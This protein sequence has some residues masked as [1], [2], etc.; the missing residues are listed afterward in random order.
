MK[1]YN[2]H[3]GLVGNT[4][5]IHDLVITGYQVGVRYEELGG[6]SNTCT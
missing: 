4:A 6:I 2:F 3:V 5:H 1:L